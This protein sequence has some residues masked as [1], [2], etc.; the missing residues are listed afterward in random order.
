M[1]SHG[2]HLPKSLSPTQTEVCHYRLSFLNPV[3]METEARSLVKDP[4]TTL[5]LG[6]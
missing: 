6:C 5:V 1:L 4:H 3:L 2:L